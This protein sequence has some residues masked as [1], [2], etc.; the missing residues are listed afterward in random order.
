M[1]AQC[2]CLTPSIPTATLISNEFTRE[3][4]AD[5]TSAKLEKACAN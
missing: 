1:I 4:D 2:G 5:K 3:L